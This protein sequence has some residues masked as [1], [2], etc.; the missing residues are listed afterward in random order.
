MTKFCKTKFSLCAAMMVGL[1]V[2]QIASAQD[3]SLSGLFGCE[4]I[5]NAQAQL[6][7][8]QIETAKLRGEAAASAPVL[9]PAP[10]IVPGPTPPV[11]DSLAAQKE[12]LAL[13]KQQLA[14]EKDRLAAEKKRVAA[15]EKQ[16][17]E[18][19]KAKSPDT[20]AV[21]IASASR[22][23]VSGYVRFT[24]E[25]GEVWQQRESGRVRL[26][27]A[28]P[29]ILVIKKKSLGSF[30]GRVNDKSPSVRIKRVK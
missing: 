16:V 3:A 18:K 8:F 2:P 20:R 14:A 9:A 26:G 30:I 17:K 5:S 15:L 4:A 19:D 11:T 13:E 29:D 27:K 22:S 10:I 7:C 25:N 23:P 24:L 28:E 6:S 21:A 12:S 1:G